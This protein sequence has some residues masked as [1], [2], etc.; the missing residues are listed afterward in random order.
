M[1]DVFEFTT[2]QPAENL[3]QDYPKIVEQRC[4]RVVHPPELHAP[5]GGLGSELPDLSV[6]GF[7]PPSA[8]VKFLGYLGFE[9]DVAN[10]G[11]RPPSFLR[12]LPSED[13][14]DLYAV[15]EALY[16]VA[17]DRWYLPLLE[18]A[19]K[20]FYRLSSFRWH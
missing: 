4:E 7:D 18:Q 19:T 3:S 11:K 1:Q 10:V 14:L 13:E 6:V 8:A 15:P 20:L 5:A 16:G 17:G 9:G 2:P 12:F